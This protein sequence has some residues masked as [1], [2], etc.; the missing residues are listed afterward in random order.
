[1]FYRD[2]VYCG[3]GNVFYVLSG[4]LSIAMISVVNDD[5]NGSYTTTDFWLGRDSDDIDWNEGN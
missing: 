1:M 5:V 4:L 2:V 3:A